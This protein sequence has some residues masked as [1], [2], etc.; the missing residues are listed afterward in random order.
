MSNDGKP[1]L[2]EFEDAL[3]RLVALLESI[4]DADE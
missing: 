1:T 3:A 4:P 2:K